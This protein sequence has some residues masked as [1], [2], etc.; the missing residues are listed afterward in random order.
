MFARFT[1]SA[2]H[3]FV[4]AG[5]LALEAGHGRLGTDMLLL[6]LA[7]TRPFSLDSFTATAASLRERLELRDTR[8]LLAGLGI[9][10]DD[11]RQR[12]LPGVGEWRLTR[13]R[14]RPLR[15]VL[16]GPRGEIA[17]TGGA[18]KVVEVAL[19]RP[20][21]VTGESLLWGLLADGGN[22]AARHLQGAGV[23]VRALVNEVRMPTRP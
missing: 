9:S 21:A 22:G 3:A 13:H 10:L 2:R 20:G 11:V 17:L 16:Y 12:T 23:N 1:D 15:V 7:E 5:V 19:W 6:A 4:T 8:A 18:R 14:L